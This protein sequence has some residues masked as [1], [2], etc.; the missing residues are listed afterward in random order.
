MSFSPGIAK[1]K[2][3]IRK[4]AKIVPKQK[5]IEENLEESEELIWNFFPSSFF[6]SPLQP[7][8]LSSPPELKKRLDYIN[9]CKIVPFQG[10]NSEFWFP[11]LSEHIE[12]ACF[13]IQKVKGILKRLLHRWKSYKLVPINTTDFVTLEPVRIPVR[14][15]DWEKNKC[16]EFEASSLM[17]DLTE[18][19]QKHDGFFEDPKFPRNPLT[20]NPL[21]LSQTISVWLQLSF[22]NVNP[23]SAFCNFRTARWNLKHYKLIYSTPLKYRSFKN[24]MNDLKQEDSL[25]RL[26]DF[27]TMVHD[28]NDVPFLPN[29]YVY[30]INHFPE[31]LIISAW[32]RLCANYYY[33]EILYL[34]QPDNRYKLQDNILLKSK[35]LLVRYHEICK[36]VNTKTCE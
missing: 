18:C 9:Y 15:V 26:M 27:I 10:C 24:T 11:E 32:K 13:Q 2:E 3:P 5:E 35:E 19:L 6:P 31:S 34:N 4:K 8:L 16:W 14:I 7:F 25:E 33:A 22:S 21:T 12:N 29:S 28:E 30:C 20:N 36:M 1:S 23:S 17:R